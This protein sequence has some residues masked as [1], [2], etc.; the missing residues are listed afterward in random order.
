[1]DF[2]DITIDN[3]YLR[4][5][6]KNSYDILYNN[7]TLEFY[8][9]LLFCP[10]GLEEKYNNYFINFQIENIYTNKNTIDTHKNTID[11]DFYDFLIKLELNIK[12]LVNNLEKSD[13][14]INSQINKK[15]NMLY[16]KLIHKN[17]KILCKFTNNENENLNIYKLEKKKYYFCKLNCDS[18]WITNNTIYFK[19]K[20]KEIKLNN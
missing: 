13:Y 20:I 5:K 19:Y 3:I 18:L 14:N 17:K 15:S 4:K 12:T 6:T 1:M 10:F 2:R 11:N 7:T 16:T 8:T 9:I